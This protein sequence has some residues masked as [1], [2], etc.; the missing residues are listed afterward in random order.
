MRRVVAAATLLAL[1]L[2]ACAG[3]ESEGSPAK[4]QV[5]GPSEV[6]RAR[7]LEAGTDYSVVARGPAKVGDRTAYWHA[8]VSDKE[9]LGVLVMPSKTPETAASTVVLMDP[10]SGKVREVAEPP[11]GTQMIGADFSSRYIVWTET[12]SSNIGN[13]PWTLRSFDRRTGTVRTLATSDLLLEDGPHMS[14][15]QVYL[16]IADSEELPTT[17]SA[18]RVAVDGPSELKKVASDVQGVFPYGRDLAIIRDGEFF[19]RKAGTRIER[20]ADSQRRG[21]QKCGATAAAD[22]IVQ[23]DNHR[24]RPRLTVQAQ[25]ATYEIRFPK[26]KPHSLGYGVGYLG[27]AASWVTFTFDDQAFVFDLKSETIGRFNGAQSVS[28]PG[29]SFGDAIPYAEIGQD[30]PTLFV[31]LLP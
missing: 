15:G 23:C 30:K 20:R 5:L 18:Y 11:A 31:R 25:H 24:G 21:R 14:D 16:T 12:T 19:I 1:G 10:K 26:P 2:T 8:L 22:V 7:T 17:A 4:V 27:C 3:P 29:R 6:T 9:M 13:A 28:A